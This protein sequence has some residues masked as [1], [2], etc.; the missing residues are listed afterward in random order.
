MSIASLPWAMFTTLLVILAIAVFLRQSTSRVGRLFCAMLLL[1][2]LWFLAI[3]VMLVSRN[4]PVAE[5]WG[6]I[7][8]AAIVL[9]LAA[10]YDFNITALRLTPRRNGV[11]TTSWVVVTIVAGLVL[12]T[13]LIVDSAARFSWGFYPQFTPLGGSLFV[14]FIVAMLAL[15]L[16]ELLL[17][18]RGTDDQKT[19]QRLHSL[20]LSLAIGSLTFLDLVPMWGVDR[21]PIAYIPVGALMIFSWRSVQRHRLRPLSVGG[22]A[23]EILET[24]ADALFVLDRNG[25]I[26]AV[27]PAVQKILG[28]S[29]WEV[30][31]RSIDMLEPIDVERTI[32][33]TL[34]DMVRR[35]AVRDQER[36]FRHKEGDLIDVSI[37][38]SPV[39]EGNVEEGAI[40][41]AR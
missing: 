19:R 14:L 3:A 27:N 6:R 40:L 41:I 26:S 28:Y 18:L 4:G 13:P 15:N 24:M 22:A 10:L 31:G 34:R 29:D 12:F 39:T 25:R 21:R 2:A 23:R 11:A 7:A 36:V 35:G 32:S 5:W 33:K 9:L 8:L 20:M 17:E 16:V 30:I 37:S 38:V 1:A